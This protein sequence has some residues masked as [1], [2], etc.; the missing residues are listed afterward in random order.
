MNINASYLFLEGIVSGRNDVDSTRVGVTAK[1][2]LS[3]GREWGSLAC[4]C[5]P[6]YDCWSSFK[7]SRS[8]SIRL[9][10]YRTMAA[11]VV[12]PYNYRRDVVLSHIC[13]I[14]WLVWQLLSISDVLVCSRKIDCHRYVGLMIE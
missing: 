12:V 13:N 14:D 1:K 11:A 8:R 3:F 4:S 6:R 10:R 5:I 9:R 7:G 2:G